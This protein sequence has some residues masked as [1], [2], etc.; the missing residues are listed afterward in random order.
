L[1]LVSLTLDL[2]AQT[3][4]PATDFSGRWA[5]VAGASKPVELPLGPGFVIAQDTTTFTIAYANTM[6]KPETYRLD[7][8]KTTRV[9]SGDA[10]RQRTLTS[11]AAWDGPKFVITT[12]DSFSKTQ[13][14]YAIDV[15][16][17]GNLIVTASTTMLY[18]KGG[19]LTVDTIGPFVRVYKKD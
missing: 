12:E 14:V 8:S 18:T 16:G 5:P 11:S 13:T 7:G 19:K 15:A 17:G 9:D 1:T 3:P 10:N 4:K 2:F 6:V